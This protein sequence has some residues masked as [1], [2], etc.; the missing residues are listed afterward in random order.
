M[1]VLANKRGGNAGLFH[2]SERIDNFFQTVEAALGI[3]G[4]L[5]DV[6]SNW[7]DFE[8]KWVAIINLASGNI[9]VSFQLMHILYKVN[10]S[11]LFH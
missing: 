5:S 3:T 11:M 4:G 1:L 10:Q 9:I 8:D 2:T 7:V 6:K